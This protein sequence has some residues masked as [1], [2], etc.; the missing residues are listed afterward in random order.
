M[1]R[2][3]FI[4][5]LSG[6]GAERVT[7]NNANAWI[8]RGDKVTIITLAPVTEDF[9]TLDANI[10]RIGLNLLSSSNS[11][12]SGVFANIQRVWRLRRILKKLRPDVLIGMETSA[13]VIAVL[14]NWR[15]PCCVVVAEHIYPPMLPVSSIW[16]RLRRW[17]Y[18]H[19]SVV[20]ALTEESRA[21]LLRNCPGSNVAVIPN[22]VQFPLQDGPSCI[23]ADQILP[24]NHRLILA[25]GRLAPQKGFDM[26]IT[27]FSQVA[28]SHTDWDLVILGEGNE[29]KNLLSEVANRGLSDRIFLP[30]AAGN[31]SQ[32]YKRADL[33]VMSSRFEGFPCTLIEAMAHSL[34]V[35]S[36]DCDTGPRDIIRHEIDGVLVT[37]GDVPALASILSQLIKDEALLRR[38]ATQAVEVRDRF[39]MDRILNLWDEVI[40]DIRKRGFC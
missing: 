11:S 23:E 2:A 20:L 26:L 8:A 19:A 21:W 18:P 27:A 32:W 28:A 14:A 4:S 29:R 12:V 34:A 37:A 31:I 17:T 25:V 33:F 9:Y 15:M 38:Y 24:E 36:F 16:Q 6:G 39:S 22:A 10:R 1:N 3:I 5:S 7:V 40:G 35:V 30:G 13:N